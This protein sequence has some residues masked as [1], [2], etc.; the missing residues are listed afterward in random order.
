MLVE[1][2]R[3]FAAQD[4]VSRSVL[5]HTRLI[6]ASFDAEEA[7]LRGSRAW[8]RTHR[9]EIEALPSLA[10]NIDSIYKAADLQFMVS[11]LNSHIALDR[12]L[13]RLCRD[14]AARIGYPSAEGVMRFGGGGTDAA[15]LAKAG[16]C[17]TT[18]IAMSTRMVRDGL[19]YHTMR[20]TVA[21]IEPHAVEACLAVAER[22]ACEL[23]VQ[24]GVEKPNSDND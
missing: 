15:E 12:D 19:V 8:V 14:I 9:A 11:D 21:A 3:S 17:A 10:L 5:K 23:D 20:D 18:M 7:G 13:V 1:L 4:A 6:F 16:V 24:A 2:A 22:L